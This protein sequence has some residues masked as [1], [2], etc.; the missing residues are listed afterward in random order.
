M[1]VPVRKE[2][3]TGLLFF[4]LC[5]QRLF[6]HHHPLIQKR[7]SIQI[8]LGVV[9]APSSESSCSVLWSIALKNCMMVLATPSCLSPLV[10]FSFCS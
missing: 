7:Q 5:L 2:V 1:G 4:G 8:C 3:L 9:E 10:Q 6:A